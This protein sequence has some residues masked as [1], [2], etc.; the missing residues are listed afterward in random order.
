MDEKTKLVLD[1]N[2]W[3]SII[4]D[5]TDGNEFECL[6]ED[7]KI[8]FQKKSFRKSHLLKLRKFRKAGIVS[9]RQFLDTMTE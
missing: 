5:K 8:S 3:I 1:T 7:E 4:S 9:P 2:V 6:I